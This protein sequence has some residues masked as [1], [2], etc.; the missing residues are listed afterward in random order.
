M[1][2]ATTVGQQLSS[3]SIFVLFFIELYTEE[4]WGVPF[5]LTSLLLLTLAGLLLRLYADVH[6]SGRNLLFIFILL[7]HF[8]ISL[9]S[10]FSY[11]FSILFFSAYRP[12]TFLSY[13][14][15]LFSE[16]KKFIDSGGDSIWAIACGEDVSGII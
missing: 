13:S 1:C 12:L 14:K 16:C 11:S 2:D 9:Y 5:L 3:V 6:F 4:Q 10:Y 8:S 7:Y 15:A